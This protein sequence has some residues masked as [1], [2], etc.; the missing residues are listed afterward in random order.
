MEHHTTLHPYHVLLRESEQLRAT[1]DFDGTV[2]EYY[3]YCLCYNDC[4]QSNA[5]VIESNV[6]NRDLL[7]ISH[8][9]GRNQQHFEQLRAFRN[10]SLELSRAKFG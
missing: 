10:E 9:F 3:H 7:L 1:L 5:G 2:Y 8:S 6:L 4:L